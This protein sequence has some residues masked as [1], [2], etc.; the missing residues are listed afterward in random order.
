M[1]LQL[2]NQRKLILLLIS[3]ITSPKPKLCIVKFKTVKHVMWMHFY[4]I[5]GRSGPLTKEF[6]TFP[7]CIQIEFHYMFK[8]RK[9]SGNSMYNCIT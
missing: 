7:L 3:T 8:V 9:C 6:E 4:G 2:L 1:I 5:C